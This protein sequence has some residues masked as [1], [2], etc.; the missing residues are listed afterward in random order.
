[1]KQNKALSDRER[2]DLRETR[3][4]LFRYP[5]DPLARACNQ[6][7]TSV[8]LQDDWLK[9]LNAARLAGCKDVC[10]VILSIWGIN[11]RDIERVYDHR[12]EL[13][14]NL[15]Q[16]VDGIHEQFFDFAQSMLADRAVENDIRKHKYFGAV[17]DAVR[18]MRRVLD[19]LDPI[20]EDYAKQKN[21]VL[22]SED[23]KDLKSA[24]TKIKAPSSE[25]G[26]VSK[27]QLLVS[28]L[29]TNDNWF[30][31][32]KDADLVE[33]IS[34][35]FGVVLD[36]LDDSNVA[37]MDKERFKDLQHICMDTIIKLR[38]ENSDLRD[39]AADIAHDLLTGRSLEE[40]KDARPLFDEIVATVQ[41]IKTIIDDRFLAPAVADEHGKLDE[42]E[43]T[44][45]TL[46]NETE[47]QTAA[48]D[49]HREDEQL[50]D[51]TDTEPE[52][53]KN[54]ARN[55]SSSSSYTRGFLPAEFRLRN[56]KNPGR[57]LSYG[58]PN[59]VR[60]VDEYA[61]VKLQRVAKNLV[62]LEMSL[63]KVKTA[64]DDK[65]ERKTENHITNHLAQ[66][67]HRLRDFFIEIDSV[68]LSAYNIAPYRK[69]IHL[70][71]KA[72]DKLGAKDHDGYRATLN[73]LLE[74]TPLGPP[75]GKAERQRYLE[76]LFSQKGKTERLAYFD[77]LVPLRDA[78]H[79]LIASLDGCGYI[80]DK[81]LAVVHC[82]AQNAAW[83]ID[84]WIRSYYYK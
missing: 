74:M 60:K 29:L 24:I 78:C 2:K 65:E 41:L 51:Y 59:Q 22:T 76:D 38:R 55:S 47:Q 49:K 71:V 39:I 13:R 63:A 17:I 62:K 16:P 7:L 48:L 18:L 57:M 35:M 30:S 73:E 6:C 79:S 44:Y 31:T 14:D 67:C 20:T 53:N 69:V 56:V 58:L 61:R 70:C 42:L 27:L 36:F 15:H 66:C 12:A 72:A 82:I 5:G 23:V 25:D 43:L 21:G 46:F 4:I 33:D 37:T 3:E 45:S 64:S 26:A 77:K 80:N 34:E 50:E 10:D 8:L 1:M 81:L 11:D 75:D 32:D 40:I 68:S 54:S 9:P 19:T 83:G 84:Y 52:E 28:S